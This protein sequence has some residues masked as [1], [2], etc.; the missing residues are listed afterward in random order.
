MALPNDDNPNEKNQKSNEEEDTHDYETSNSNE[1]QKSKCNCNLSLNQLAAMISNLSTSYNTTNISLALPIL[2]AILQTPEEEKEDRDGLIAS[3]LL[4]GMAVGQI[5]GGTLGDVIGRREALILVILL[6]MVASIGSATVPQKDSTLQYT[7]IIWRF[8]LGVGAGGVY[9]L[10]A[11]LSAEDTTS[12]NSSSSIHHSDKLRQVALTFSTQ[13]VGF[14]LVPLITYPLLLICTEEHLDVVWRVILGLGAL[15]GVF[16]FALLLVQSCSSSSCFKCGC[17]FGKQRNSTNPTSQHSFSQDE[18]SSMASSTMK[19]S[20][21]TN[22]TKEHQ[23]HESLMAEEDYSHHDGSIS[24]HTASAS[25]IRAFS[26]HSSASTTTSTKGL[27]QSIKEEPHLMRKLCGTAGTWFLFDVLFYGNTLFQPVVLEAAFGRGG[28]GNREEDEF[29]LLLQTARDGLILTS[30]ALPG[31]FVSALVVGRYTSFFGLSR[32]KP[33]STEK[34]CCTIHQTPRYIQSQGF[35]FMFLLYTIIGSLWTQLASIQA[36]LLLVYGGTFFFANYGPNA[37]T[38]MLPSITYSE[39]CRSTLNGISA[40]AGKA[41]ALVGTLVFE[42]AAEKWGDNVV[43]LICAGLSVL[44]LILTRICIVDDYSRGEGVDA[45]SSSHSFSPV[46]A[47][48]EED[49]VNEEDGGVMA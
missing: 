42:P 17:C 11:V 30:I 9:P 39:K 49:E 38:F 3:S 25:T 44:A 34:K 5:I 21:S 15:P 35:T 31:Y 16:L 23:L 7:L 46:G 14:L 47:N 4:G 40:A 48:E 33:T 10:A 26:I 27:W 24:F 8:F 6:Q 18:S 19:Q 32:N 12:S 28:D 13:G 45:S 22:T 2:H 29:Q 36:L 1:I 41:G 43:M 37:T 20:L